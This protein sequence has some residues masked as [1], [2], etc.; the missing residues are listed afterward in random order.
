LYQ[1]AEEPPA[2]W[3]KTTHSLLLG[4]MYCLKNS[5]E[6]RPKNQYKV[7][8]IA[9]INQISAKDPQ[10]DTDGKSSTLKEKI[11]DANLSFL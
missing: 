11:G 8:R 2:P 10:K 1:T 3:M 7:Y 9:K 5:M 6:V 4:C